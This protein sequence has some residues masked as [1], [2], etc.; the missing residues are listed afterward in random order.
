MNPSALK[1]RESN[2]SYEQVLRGSEW[3]KRMPF[4][5]AVRYIPHDHF[6]LRLLQ[7]RALFI[8]GSFA[9]IPQVTLVILADNNSIKFQRTLESCLL[10]SAHCFRILIASHDPEILAQAQ[11]QCQDRLGRSPFLRRDFIDRISYSEFVYDGVKRSA[12][13]GGYL[14]AVRSGDVLHPSCVASVYLEL[15]RSSGRADVC[16]WNEMHVAFATD[17]QV[18]KFLRKPLFEPYTFFH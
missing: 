10:Q 16:L 2:D 18:V 11:F 4:E 9:S 1:G 3:L 12:F 5:H 7:E 8:E 13:S 6:L 17:V 15:N 14:V